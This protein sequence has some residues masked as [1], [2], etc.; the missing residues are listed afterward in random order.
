MIRVYKS[1]CA[2]LS[3]STKRSYNS[4]DVK[5]Q[6]DTDQYNKCYICERVRD[7][8]LQV[9]HYKSRNNNTDLQQ[10][11]S[12]LFHA[13]SYC[14]SRKSD[15]F[16]NILN[17]T[18]YNLEEIISQEV[19]FINNKALFSIANTCGDSVGEDKTIGLL[20]K[21][22]NGK[23]GLRNRNCTLLFNQLIISIKK[24][25]GLILR[26]IKDSNDAEAKI[27][28]KEELSINKEFLGF[29]YWVICS[30]ADLMT[31]FGNDIVW[32]K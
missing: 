28:I 30:N 18:A 27:A 21:I 6:L 1:D 20:E 3:L 25:N 9:E 16:D 29:K 5:K 12:N 23:E 2:P 7:T 31:E 14:N 11:W 15:S 17:P 26:Y 8:D 19:D 22:C 32:N 24:F 13:C 10:E 4:D